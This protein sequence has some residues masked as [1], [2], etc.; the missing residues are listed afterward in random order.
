LRKRSERQQRRSEQR[1]ER[2]I[3]HQQDR[4]L[5]SFDKRSAETIELIEGPAPAEDSSV[6]RDPGQ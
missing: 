5:H 1:I 6:P 4:G 2:L 3:E